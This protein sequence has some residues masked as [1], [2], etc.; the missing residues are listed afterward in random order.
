LLTGPRGIGKTTGVLK[1]ATALKDL[2]ISVFGVATPKI[3]DGDKVVGLAVQDLATGEQ[4]Q[5]AHIDDEPG[6]RQG[7][8]RFLP[9]GIC[10]ANKACD[11]M[12][13]EGLAVIDEIGPLE[14]RG[15]G[16]VAGFE[17][18]QKG[19]Y[20]SALVVVRPELADQMSR[21]VKG[22]VSVIAWEPHCLD[23]LIAEIS[24]AHKDN[25]SLIGMR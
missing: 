10:F 9:E 25:A 7:P 18:L 1:L 13:H 19:Q 6:I 21:I 23:I 8:W 16:F 15:E 14:L 24:R 22:E 11:P 12:K 3:F 4:I 2:G 5:L 20:E 17:A